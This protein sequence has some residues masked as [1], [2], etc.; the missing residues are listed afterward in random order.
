MEILPDVHITFTP[1]SK[2]SMMFLVPI[3]KRI[4]T[5]SMSRQKAKVFLSAG[6]KAMGAGNA[7]RM[8]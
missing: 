4:R 2:A 5:I 8:K 3:K 6:R 1:A 7:K